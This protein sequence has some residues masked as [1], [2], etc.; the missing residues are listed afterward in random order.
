MMMIFLHN[1]VQSQLKYHSH[2]D[3]LVKPAIA[4]VEPATSPS[5]HLVEHSLHAPADWLVEI[6][7]Q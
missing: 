7:E 4:S 3:S 1:D 6:I 5:Q 2:L